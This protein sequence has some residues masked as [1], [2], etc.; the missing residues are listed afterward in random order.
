MS[1]FTS[2]L[3][4]ALATQPAVGSQDFSLNLDLSKGYSTQEMKVNSRPVRF[5]AYE[6]ISYVQRPVE[7]AY[8]KLNLYVPEEY[9]L[10]EK[11]GNFDAQTAPIFFP[12]SVGGYMPSL[13]KSILGGANAGGPPGGPGG[14]GGPSGMGVPGGMGGP[15]G[16]GGMGINTMLQALSHGYVVVSP[17]ARGSTLRTA[18]GVFTGKAPAVIVDLKAA[19]RFIRFNDAVIPGDSEKIISNGTS[20]GGAVSSLLGASGNQPEYEPYLEALGAAK[21]N[22]HVFAVNAYCPITNLENADAAYEWQFF[23]VNEVSGRGG[24]QTLSTDQIEYSRLLK[25][26]FPAYVNGLNLKDL[27]GEALTLKADGTG[28]FRDAVAALL[29]TSFLVAAQRTK[30]EVPQEWLKITPNLPEVD[31]SGYAKWVRRMKTPGAFDARD[32]STRENS[33][34]G[35]EKIASRHFTV[36]ASKGNSD[37]EIASVDTVRLMNPMSFLEKS[38][39]SIPDHWRI[40][41]G[42]SDRDTSLAISF[43]LATKLQNIGKDVDLAY[44]WGVGHSGDYDLS[45]LFAWMDKIVQAKK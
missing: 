8:Q 27:R 16:P 30:V 11:I 39:A 34:F 3:S 44:P 6:G 45:E 10:G 2:F 7:P 1:F 17:G 32:L 22:D 18:D 43:I 9:F 35:T 28:T 40:R 42:A 4:V 36:F 31:F 14:T 24:S 15:G 41:H 25:Q 19:V 37:A 33:L 26:S 5:R 38:K 21:A 29:G 12:N 13:P 23:G 20:A